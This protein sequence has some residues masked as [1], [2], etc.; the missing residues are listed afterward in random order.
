MKR[1]KLPLDI[2]ELFVM[3]KEQIA[4]L[5]NNGWHFNKE[6][7]EFASTAM[8]KYN[9]QTQKDEKIPMIKKDEVDALLKKYNITLD[10]SDGYDY[11]YVAQMCKA[12]FLGSSVADEH[13]MAMF[14]KDMCD[15]ADQ[16]DG[17]ILRR[18]IADMTGKGEQID[19]LQ[20]IGKKE[21]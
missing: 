6:L 17:F 10:N 5:S 18:W 11:V 13:R 16:A 9:K 19:W 8:Y 7:Y 20:Y 21:E 3:P 4:Y 14:I 2:Y 15:D 1:N 12:D